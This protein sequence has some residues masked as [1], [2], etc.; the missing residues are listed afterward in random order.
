[1][2]LF[3]YNK[4][5]LALSNH[6]YP[7]N[8]AVCIT[9][10]HITCLTGHAMGAQVGVDGEDGEDEG[11]GE[12]VHVVAIATATATTNGDRKVAEA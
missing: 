9:Q 8:H 6:I 11:D 4:L 5:N 12:G 3:C 1:M 7:S 2:L 10:I